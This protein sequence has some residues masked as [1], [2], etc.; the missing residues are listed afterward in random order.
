[1]NRYAYA[2]NNPTSFVDPS[3]LDYGYDCGNNCVGVVGTDDSDGG[4][5][6]CW[7]CTEY[8]VQTNCWWCALP[9]SQPPPP[10]P[11]P[12]NPPNNPPCSK[13]GLLPSSVGFSYGGNV[14]IGGGPNAGFAST[15]GAGAG[16][17][18][19]SNASS[20]GAF[21]DGGAAGYAG[22]A[23]AGLPSQQG[24]PFAFGAYAGAGPSVWF[25]N[26]HTAQQLAGPFTTYSLNAGGGPFKGLSIQLSTGGGIWQLSIGLP[27]PFSGLSTPSLAFDELTTT[28]TATHAGCVQ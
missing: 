7:W 26:A 19:D 3:G 24:Q 1:M 21:A 14:D 2:L 11:A 22:P 27:I 6:V 13:A 4:D 16:Y 17:F 23:Y 12:N 8:G 25:S 28:T 9:P 20:F 15:A 18:Y 10:T 5:I